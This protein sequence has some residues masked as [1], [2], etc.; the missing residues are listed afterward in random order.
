MLIAHNE[1]LLQIT[2]G[3]WVIFKRW[4]SILSSQKCLKWRGYGIYAYFFVII[5]RLYSN[6]ER[7]L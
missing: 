5:L 3:Q 1:L 2:N 7:K 6:F 4:K